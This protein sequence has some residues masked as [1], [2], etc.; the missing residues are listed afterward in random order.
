MSVLAWFERKAFAGEIV[1]DYGSVEDQFEGIIRVR[2]SILLCRRRGRLQ[3]VFRNLRTAPFAFR[4][5]YT[6]IDVTTE[7][8]RRL[9]EMLL[10]ARRQLDSAHAP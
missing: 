4:V 5:H 3:F 9:E 2:T 1:H 10:D 6:H 7:N 8:I